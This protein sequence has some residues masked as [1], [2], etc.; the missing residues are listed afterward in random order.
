MSAF[1]TSDAWLYRSG[2][3]WTEVGCYFLFRI[4]MTDLDDVG[5]VSRFVCIAIAPVALL[6]LL[7]K[8]SGHNPFAVLGG[9]NATALVRDGH[10]L[11]QRG[12]LRIRSSPA[13]S[14]PSA[15]ASGSPCASVTRWP[16]SP[17]SSLA[18]R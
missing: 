7:E 11:A 8:A 2:I 4:F 15:S 12:R 10:I 5:T 18:A 13:S 6:L 9:F 16:A 1:H 17:A 14:A 3:V